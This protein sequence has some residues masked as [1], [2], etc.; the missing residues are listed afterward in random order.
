MNGFPR[1]P[2]QSDPVR[3]NDHRRSPRP[4]GG[5]ISLLAV[6]VLLFTGLVLALFPAFRAGAQD[7]PKITQTGLTNG[8]FTLRFTSPSGFNSRLERSANLVDWSAVYTF[9]RTAASQLHTDTGARFASR[10]FYRIVQL[11]ETN[12]LTGDHIPTTEGDLVV[13]PVNH[14]SLVM[15]WKDQIIYADPVGGAD[16]YKNLPKPTLIFVTDIHPDHA[17]SVTINGIGGANAV[18][19]V[20]P[21]VLPMLSSGLAAV[22]RV[23][24]NGATLSVAG[25]GVEAIPMYNLTPARLQYHTKGRGNGYIL[26]LGGKRVYLSG[27]TEDIQ[28]M[29]NLQNI[30]LAFLCMNLPYTMD[31]NQAANV[32]RVFRPRRVVPYHY[33]DSN[34][35]QFKQLVG[36]DLNIEVLLR[37][38]Y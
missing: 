18:L 15:S 19:V 3:D 33:S 38:W 28:E 8:E 2:R 1:R 26:T 24:A 32:T 9:P 12:A 4:P 25:L 10:L 14:A 29:R 31:I 35:T 20:P 36:R 30:D 37:K 7:H 34:V 5:G 17:D 11:P 13:H 22:S 6:R 21:A 27:D 23:M 16:L